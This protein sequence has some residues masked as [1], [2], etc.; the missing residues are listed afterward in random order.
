MLNWSEKND[1]SFCH[2]WNHFSIDKIGQFVYDSDHQIFASSFT[3][4]KISV[5]GSQSL[6]SYKIHFGWNGIIQLISLPLLKV[7]Q[8]GHFKQQ[9]LPWFC[10]KKEKGN[11]DSNSK[12]C[13]KNVTKTIDLWQEF[14]EIILQSEEKC[15]QDIITNCRRILK[16]KEYSYLLP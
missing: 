13:H 2:Y 1:E 9:K 10:W 11:L 6:K 14:E 15:V 5:L 8:Q 12:H 16:F 7:W 3:L 4:W